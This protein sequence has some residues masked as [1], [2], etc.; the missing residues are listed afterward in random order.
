MLL[1]TTWSFQAI[2]YESTTEIGVHIFGL[3]NCLAT[4]VYM[5]PIYSS[6]NSKQFGEF[7]L[8]NLSMIDQILHH[9]LFIT[10]YIMRLF[11]YQCMSITTRNGYCRYHGRAIRI[12]IDLYQSE[13]IRSF[14]QV[15]WNK[16]HGIE[17]GFTYHI[18]VSI[19]FFLPVREYYSNLQ[20]GP[21]I[22]MNSRHFQ[23]PRLVVHCILIRTAKVSFGFTLSL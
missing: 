1:S 13:G 21:V 3:Q 18:L 4:L 16:T 15:T 2:K 5:A 8:N 22:S 23:N 6:A 17:Q 11:L 19:T 10:S 7:N 20:F 12:R 14:R 9:T